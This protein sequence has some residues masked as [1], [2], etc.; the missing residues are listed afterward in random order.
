M[1]ACAV[2]LMFFSVEMC[3]AH[4]FIAGRTIFAAHLWF[5]VGS[6]Q[7]NKEVLEMTI[8]NP[9]MSEGKNKD[10]PI[11]NIDSVDALVQ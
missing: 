11:S 5:F 6:V 1:C 9:A 4:M 10:L 7:N 3:K 8:R 2:I